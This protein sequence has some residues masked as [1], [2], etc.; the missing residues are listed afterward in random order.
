MSDVGEYNSEYGVYSINGI[1]RKRRGGNSAIAAKNKREYL[2][3][4]VRP[5]FWH[6]L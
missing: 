5:H 1:G 2:G 3:R 4:P 6:K